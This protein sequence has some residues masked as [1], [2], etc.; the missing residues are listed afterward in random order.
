VASAAWT[1]GGGGAGLP[2]ALVWPFG[3]QANAAQFGAFALTLRALP[4][5]PHRI[6]RLADDAIA[7]DRGRPSR[8]ASRLG[9]W[10]ATVPGFRRRSFGRS[11]C[12][13]T[14]GNSERSR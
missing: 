9:G 6:G 11:A 10:A 2:A 7:R 12:R 4:E 3:V 1:P 13:R 8:G 5:A 14:S